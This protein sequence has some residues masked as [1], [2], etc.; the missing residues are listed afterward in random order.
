LKSIAVVGSINTDMFTYLTKVPSSGET[1]RGESFSTGFGGKGANQAL[2]SARLGARTFMV[3]CIGEDAFGES[4]LDHFQSEEIQVNL[5]EKVEGSS[6]VATILVE[7]NGN[8]RIV[9]IPGANHKI[10]KSQVEKSINSISN[11]GIIL[12]QFEIPQEVTLAAFRV[13]KE[14]GAITILNPAPAQEIKKE[15]LDICDWLIVNESEFQELNPNGLGPEND[16]DIRKL[17]SDFKLN[18]IVTLG[19]NGVKYSNPNIGKVIQIDTNKVDAV[20][21]TGA[22]DT[23]VGAFA[24]GI[25]NNLETIDA[26]KLGCN[27]AALSVTRYGAQESMPSRLEA[28]KILNEISKIQ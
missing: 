25:L 28:I 13:A 7:S 19:E 17:A 10:K 22:G 14:Q 26:I 15:L 20:D 5:I 8:N 24:F 4:L 21:T 18:L 16:S 23:F 11:L 6:G 3:G 12:G 9:I 27:C 2:I 1:I